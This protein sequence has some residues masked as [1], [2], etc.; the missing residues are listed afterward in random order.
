MTEPISR[1][2]QRR[3]FAV[4]VAAAVLGWSRDV[5]A[6]ANFGFAPPV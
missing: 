6:P 5:E 3:L 1:R 2:R 4:K